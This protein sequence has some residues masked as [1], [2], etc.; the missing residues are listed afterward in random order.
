MT[1]REILEALRVERRLDKSLWTQLFSTWTDDDRAFAAELARE[2]SV[3]RFEHDIFFRGI[4]EFTNICKNNCYYCGIRRDNAGVSRYRLTKD[5]ILSCCA[6]GHALGFRTFV[7]QGGEDGYF[8]DERLADILQEI[9]A[10]YPDCAVTLSIGERS[11]ESYQRLFDAGARRCLLRHETANE[12]HYGVLHP[13]ELSWKNRMRCLRDLKAIG[14]QTGAGFMVGTPGQT[15]EMLAE[16]MLFLTDF[17][18][19]M[20][21]VGPFLPHQ[22][23]PFRDQPAGSPELTLFVLSLARLTLPDLLLP[24][25]TALGTVRGDGRQLGVLA[26]A[27]VVMPNLSPLAVR[28]KYLLYDNKTG[29]DCDAK[30][31]LNALRAQM[32]QIGYRLVESRGDYVMRTP[33][34]EDP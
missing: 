15:P 9:C 33:K 19:E 21:G 7:L 5:E 8:T 13:P 24:A 14:Y 3:A 11:R 23:T 18:P 29:T 27:N 16:E 6:E 32:E 4:I 26:G 22:G 10:Q 20:Y 1:N 31:G 30:A 2:V 17:R 28:K 12:A 34:G 25:T